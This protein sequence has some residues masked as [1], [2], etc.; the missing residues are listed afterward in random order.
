[1]FDIW[2]PR[3]TPAE[4]ALVTALSAGVAGFTGGGVGP[5]SRCCRR[6]DLWPP[7]RPPLR[8]Q[9]ASRGSPAGRSVQSP[10]VPAGAILGQ[11]D[12]V[13]LAEQ[14]SRQGRAAEALTLT[15]PLDTVAAPSH[16]RL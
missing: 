2:H 9:P 14:L 6:S 12:P 8:G 15:A 16:Q 5:S 1:N 10:D 13:A 4:R 3:L 7:A 11:Q